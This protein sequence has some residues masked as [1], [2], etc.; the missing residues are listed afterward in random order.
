[1]GA[2]E[3]TPQAMGITLHEVYDFEYPW[4][5]IPLGMET[6][7]I[8]FPSTESLEKATPLLIKKWEENTRATETL[9]KIW[10]RLRGLPRNVGFGMMSM[11]FSNIFV[12]LKK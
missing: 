3:R 7:L 5:A 12:G 10:I 11:T 2:L 9:Q 1:V 8:E 4:K 6:Y